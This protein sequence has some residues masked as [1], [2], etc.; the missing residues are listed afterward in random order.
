M[1]RGE[2]KTKLRKGRLYC[3][4]LIRNG[5]ENREEREL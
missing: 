3:H 4:L 5:F 2:T 1:R